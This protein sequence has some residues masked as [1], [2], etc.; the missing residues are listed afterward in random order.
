[1]FLVDDDTALPTVSIELV[2]K[3][4]GLYKV[5]A[6]KRIARD[7]CTG[8][9]VHTIVRDVKDLHDYCRI[10]KLLLRLDDAFWQ[11]D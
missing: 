2:H 7:G 8:K 10:A 11:L 3:G 6:K 4:A 1:M 9:T 5:V